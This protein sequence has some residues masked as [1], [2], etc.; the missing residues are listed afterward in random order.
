LSDLTCHWFALLQNPIISMQRE[1][2]QF[3]TRCKLV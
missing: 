1:T 3:G 2:R